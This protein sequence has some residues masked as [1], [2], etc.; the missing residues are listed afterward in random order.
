[1]PR[2]GFYKPD[3]FSSDQLFNSRTC[4]S[5]AFSRITWPRCYNA[6]A[7]ILQTRSVQFS[8]SIRGTTQD[9]THTEYQSH[10]RSPTQDII[11][12]GH[13]SHRR[14][15][16]QD[17]TQHRLHKSIEIH[18]WGAPLRIILH[19]SLR[20]DGFFHVH[21]VAVRAVVARK[22]RINS[23]SRDL[24]HSISIINGRL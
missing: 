2:L 12:I 15:L 10:R 19:T 1:M 7:R 9:I 14:S 6:E 5:L 17:I 13:H 20:R 21:C 18:I 11:H 24:H 4:V 16:T 23:L 3:Q 22:R 8:C